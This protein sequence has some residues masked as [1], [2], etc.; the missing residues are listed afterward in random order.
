MA[1]GWIQLME[2]GTYIVLGVL[3]A[4]FVFTV[5]IMFM[6]IRILYT[7]RPQQI[8]AEPP[9][10]AMSPATTSIQCYI[11]M[12][13]VATA[14]LVDCGHAGLCMD[15][16]KRLLAS[17]KTCPLCRCRITRVMQVDIVEIP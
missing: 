9:A 17:S 12:E 13:H 6:A 14:M 10:V 4:V 1:T 7:L 5:C 11:C 3:M 15:C 2:L 16:G 8:E